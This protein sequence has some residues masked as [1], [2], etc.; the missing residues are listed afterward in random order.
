MRPTYTELAGKTETIRIDGMAAGEITY[1]ENGWIETVTAAR[2]DGPAERTDAYV[3][4]RLPGCHWD[5]TAAV[6]AITEALR[7]N[8]WL[9]GERANQAATLRHRAERAALRAA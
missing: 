3:G 6:A 5:Q 9:A 2:W 8:A 4:Y 1:A 7:Y